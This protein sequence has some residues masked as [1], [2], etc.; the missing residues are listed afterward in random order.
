MIDQLSV[1]RA[2]KGNMRD[3]SEGKP[4]LRLALAVLSARLAVH[5]FPVSDSLR[6]IVLALLCSLL[7]TRV[8]YA[9]NVPL[10]SVEAKKMLQARGVGKMVKIKQSD[11]K[12]IRAKIISIGE[13]SIVLQV[14]SQPTIEL[15]YGK[16][17]AVKGPGLPKAAKIAI[18]VVVVAWI[19]SL[20]PATH[21]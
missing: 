12:E 21:T 13:E 20:Y 6:C 10:N 5:I 8:S 16:V 17:T 9:A 1:G 18:W 14:G 11:G 7:T 19:A 4:K 2:L 3:L 15:P